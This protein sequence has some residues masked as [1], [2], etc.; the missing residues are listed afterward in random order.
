MIIDQVGVVGGGLMGT[1]IARVCALA[2]ADVAVCEVDAERAEAA[3]ARTERSLR[4]AAA[5]GKITDAD[6][7]GALGR[8][9]YTAALEDLAERE[10]VIEAIVEDER[11]KTDLFAALDKVVVSPSA[12]L[13]SNTSSISITKLAAATTRPERV[14]GL[15]FFNPVPAQRL[16]ELVPTL[17]TQAATI[18]RVERFASDDLRKLV[19]RSQDR[20]GFVVNA[21]LTPYL[22]SAVRMLEAGFAAAEDIDRG[23]VEG[24]AHPVGPLSLADFVGLDI[25][26]AASTSMYEEF[27]DP[28]FAPPPLLLRMVE[29]GFLGEKTGRGF[30]TY[31]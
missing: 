18:D 5:A 4:R 12:V 1:G 30:F 26:L 19:I 29:S 23:M 7:N 3:R 13:A 9:H 20:A 16:V 15:H 2:G 25:L 8:L 21:L 11:A 10:L 14:V 28:G 6:C 17:H 27:R 22:L 24:C 31:S